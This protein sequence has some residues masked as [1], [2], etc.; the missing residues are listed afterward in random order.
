MDHAGKGKDEAGVE[1]MNSQ[2]LEAAARAI[3]P[4]AWADDMFFNSV[5]QQ[6]RREK[7]LSEAQAAITAYLEAARRE[8]EESSAHYE[9]VC[10]A[11]EARIAE[12]ERVVQEAIDKL[13]DMLP[14]WA[15]TK[16]QHK[17]RKAL[18][19]D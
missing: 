19:N 18:P 1:P 9:N 11:H 8:L 3:C 2:A 4:D 10:E 7:A 12:L 15:A 5:T 16:L 17:L 14:V 13:D 6:L